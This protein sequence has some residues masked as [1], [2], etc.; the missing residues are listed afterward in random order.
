MTVLLSHVHKK[1]LKAYEVVFLKKGILCRHSKGK[2]TNALLLLGGALG[3][4]GSALGVHW[5]RMRAHWERIGSA[6]G[7]HWERI[8]SAFG[9]H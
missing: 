8:G 7:A 9:V 2:S 3:A 1:A 4:H 5:E 6:L